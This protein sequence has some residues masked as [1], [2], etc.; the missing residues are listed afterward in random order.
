MDWLT[1]LDKIEAKKWEDVFINYSFDLE[2]WTV[3]RETLL[4][5]IDKD[6]KIASELHIR[7]YMTC[8]A[9]SVSTTHPI[10]DLVEVINEFYGRFGMDNA[11]SRR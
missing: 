5:L 1:T 9:E 10:P 3:A 11:K 4:A 7:S 6:K 8:C 2:E